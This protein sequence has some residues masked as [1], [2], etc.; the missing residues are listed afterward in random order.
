MIGGGFTDWVYHRT[1]SL[2]WARQGVGAGSLAV[3]A[4]LIVPAYFID[5][6][7]LA[8]A[9]ISAGSFA[10]AF[11]GPCAYAITIDLGGRHVTPVFSF[12][13]MCGNIGATVFPLAVPPLVKA[14]GNWDVVL[15]LFAAI[16]G[17]AAVCWL[18]FDGSRSIAD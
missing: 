2:R 4:L 11:A 18:L 12:M 7:L 16:Y 15:F 5:N 6:P 9:L 10:A 17:A 1:G 14:V 8:V 13:N 3:C